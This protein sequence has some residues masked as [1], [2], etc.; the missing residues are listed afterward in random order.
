MDLVSAGKNTLLLLYVTV[1]ENVVPRLNKNDDVIEWK[2]MKIAHPRNEELVAPLDGLVWAVV[3]TPPEMP[4]NDKARNNA[5]S[6][7]TG[8][9]LH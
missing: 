4:I 5:R 6:S 7:I 8:V 2:F 9:R 1:C 3:I